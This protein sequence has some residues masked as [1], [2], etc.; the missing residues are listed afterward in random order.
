MGVGEALR[1]KSKRMTLNGFLFLPPTRVELQGEGGKTDQVLCLQRR[2]EREFCLASP[3]MSMVLRIR[4][5]TL[6]EQEWCMGS[7]HRA[8]P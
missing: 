6:H 1:E 3:G 2:E 7:S 4:G 8:K 5:V